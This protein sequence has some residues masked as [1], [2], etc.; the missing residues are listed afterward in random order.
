M[1]VFDKLKGLFYE[2]AEDVSNEEV[3]KEQANVSRVM[4]KE[5]PDEDDMDDVISERDLFKSETTFKFPIMFEDEELERV[6][7]EKNNVM[8]QYKE[9]NSSDS[10]KM[11]LVDENFRPTPILSPVYGVLDKHYEKDNMPE[12]AKGKSV[13]I[14]KQEKP[15]DIDDIRK[16]AYG[17]LEDELE[18]TMTDEID[19]FESDE[20]ENT[21][22][23]VL[24]LNSNLSDDVSLE[25]SKVTIGDAEENFD[26]FG[27][28]YDSNKLTD[29]LLNDEDDEKEDLFDM[30]DSMYE[31]N[32]EEK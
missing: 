24:N 21:E 20:E 18:K 2:D 7:R 30:I 26:D 4:Q 25:A 8:G 32:E 15:V 28:T 17:T 12:K 9:D 1:G 6:E 29:E 22:I 13:A 16:K 27:I 11:A 31:K 14:E 23:D 19:L 5:I 3:E 10:K